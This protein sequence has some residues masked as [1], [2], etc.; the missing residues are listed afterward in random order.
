MI[1]IKPILIVVLSLITGNQLFAQGG[2]ISGKITGKASSM[3]PEIQVYHDGTNLR[4]PVD[5]ESSAFKAEL[6]LKESQFIE[7]KTGGNAISY[8][9]ATPG[10]N[11]VLAIEKPTLIETNITIESESI[12]KLN[13]VMDRFYASIEENGISTRARDW[14]TSL[15]TRN[16]LALKAIEDAKITLRDNL[17]LINDLAPEFVEDFG[18]FSESFLKYINIDNMTISEIET[19]L[20]DISKKELKV[21]ALTIPFLRTY[22]TD[23]TNAYAARKL[24]RYDI[25]FDYQTEGYKSQM[26]AAE[27]CAEYIPNKSIVNFL[28]FEKLSREI[29]I[30]G[31]KHPKY[32]DFLFTNSDNFNRSAFAEKIEALKANS[33]VEGEEERVAAKDFEFYDPEGKIYTLADFKGKMLLID[34][35][36]SWCAPCKIQMPHLKEIEKHYEGKEI[37]IAKVS[38]DA[39]KDAWLKGIK[40]ENL[41]GVLLHARGDFRN[42]FPAAYG[43]NSIP[44]FMLIDADGKIITD[45]LPKP[46][47]KAQVMAIIDRELYKKELDDILLSHF[48]ALGTDNLV[49]GN[50]YR[51]KTVQSMMGL[52]INT[53]TWYTYPKS[54]RHETKPVENEIIRISLGGDFFKKKY[55]VVRPDTIFGTIANP[56]KFAQTWT[57]KLPGLDLF[58]AKNIEHAKINFA[59][60]NFSNTENMYV[61]QAVFTDRT[62]KYFIDKSD[63]LI[64]KMVQT[65][66]IDPRAGGGILAVESKFENY[67]E[68][69][70]LMIPYFTNYNNMFSFVVNEAEVKPIDS[71]VFKTPGL[72]DAGE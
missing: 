1:R 44:R 9:Y 7:I 65:V 45:N 22:L 54:F 2:T 67:K 26:I 25:I 50:G 55:V 14:H 27:A 39:S 42:P 6:A 8:L 19:N 10:E 49:S 28:F 12:Q 5:K 33:S 51:A 29:P 43:I 20:E 56:I 40:N 18:I 63:L 32:I 4:V 64:K 3:V 68:I 34:F 59:D 58:L 69:N 37:V 38:L 23:L 11:I 71:I 66:K 70:G 30:N 62:E 61:I 72:L 17:E 21:T 36:A 31:I 24:E 47:Y 13:E 57:N 16:D 46:Q 60:E 52:E 53:E 48:K 15:F 35:W 41:Q